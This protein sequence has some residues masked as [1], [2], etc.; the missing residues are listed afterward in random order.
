VITA[1]SLLWGLLPNRYAYY[2]LLR[3]VVCA[4]SVYTAHGYAQ[5]GS[6]KFGWTFGGLVVLY[7]PFLPVYLT[8]EIWMPIDLLT[9]I[10][11]FWSAL[12]DRRRP[13]AGI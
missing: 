12:R 13:P 2:M 11:L 6:S 10:F 4:V 5:A 8:R 1:V 9:A 7:N 3:V